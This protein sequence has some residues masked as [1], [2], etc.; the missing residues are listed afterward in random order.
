MAEK[1]EWYGEIPANVKWLTFA[2]QSDKGYEYNKDFTKIT[3]STDDNNSLPYDDINFVVKY[4]SNLNSR[5]CGVKFTREDGKTDKCYISQNGTT[6]EQFWKHAPK[7]KTPKAN[8]TDAVIAQSSAETS[9][10]YEVAVGN[11]NRTRPNLLFSVGNGKDENNRGNSFEV[12]KNKIKAYN[13]YINSLTANT[14]SASTIENDKIQSDK[15]DINSL[16]ADTITVKDKIKADKADISHLTANTFSATTICATTIVNENGTNFDFGNKVSYTAATKSTDAN[17]YKIGTLKI[18]DKTTDI[19]GIS[20]STGGS[21]D[22]TY[23]KDADFDS[24]TAGT[25][26]ARTITADEGHF[27]DLKT[28]EFSA[29]SAFISALTAAET[30]TEYLNVTREAHFKKLIIDEVKSVGGQIILSCANA[31]IDKVET[32]EDGNKYKLSWLAKDGKNRDLDNQFE[33]DD[34]V[35]CQNFDAKKGT[36]YSASTQY[37][38]RKCLS[39]SAETI[40]GNEYNYIVIE[41]AD[42]TKGKG[43]GIPNVG[44]NIAQLGHVGGGER[45]NAIVLSAYQSGFLDQG[46]DSGGVNNEIPFHIGYGV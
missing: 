20:G 40:S 16:T 45:A 33:V 22:G 6:F 35:V 43:Q 44:D 37:Y 42:E 8:P 36:S 25:L 29:T 1:I 13:G 24:I 7:G 2:D 26:S 27:K 39:A 3:V 10:D 30:T 15:A 19:Y 9:N 21:G 34:Y 32:L 41:G 38:W 12:D 18:D 17:A 23:P 11:F 28:T 14:L 31:I 46:G 4:N 5:T